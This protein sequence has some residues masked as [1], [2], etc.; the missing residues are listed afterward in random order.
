MEGI[1]TLAESRIAK[2]A[3]LRRAWYRAIR[4]E[5]ATVPLFG[6]EGRAAACAF[7]DNLAGVTRH[8]FDLSGAAVWT[9]D[10]RLKDH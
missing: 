4:T 8:L 3:L 5:Y 2:S 6:P 1:S 7:I 10:D 9:R